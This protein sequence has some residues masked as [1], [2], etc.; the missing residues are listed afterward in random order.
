LPRPTA[1]ELSTLTVGEWY[2]LNA[3]RI[4]QATQA[5]HEKQEVI[6]KERLRRGTETLETMCREAKARE[7]AEDRAIEEERRRKKKQLQASARKGQG[8]ARKK[9]VR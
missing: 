4:K 8:S 6:L 5:E 3:H 9:A 1:E 2:A 7:E